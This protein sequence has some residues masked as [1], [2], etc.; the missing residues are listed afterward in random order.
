MA[1]MTT[2][3]MPDYGLNSNDIKY[4]KMDSYIQGRGPNRLKYLDLEGRWVLSG[5][6]IPFISSAFHHLERLNDARTAF[7]DIT[8][9]PLNAIGMIGWSKSSIDVRVEQKEAPK[10]PKP[11]IA[12]PVLVENEVPPSPRETM[13]HR[14]AG[15][16]QAHVKRKLSIP[17]RSRSVSPHRIET[18]Y[19]V[20]DKYQKYEKH[21][22]D[23]MTRY[24]TKWGDAGYA[25][26]SPSPIPLAGEADFESNP[27]HRTPELARRP[28]SRH[29]EHDTEYDPSYLNDRQHTD[30]LRVSTK[31]KTPS[32]PYRTL[33]YGMHH[34]RRQYEL[35]P[36]SMGSD[37]SSGSEQHSPADRNADQVLMMA[38]H[39]ARH[40]QHTIQPS[41]LRRSMRY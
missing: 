24:G 3:F 33:G 4:L 29:R 18:P 9:E 37:Y 30:E 22:K 32:L 13:P 31:E 20:Y 2:L 17:D 1:P 39:E 38:F 10:K 7:R 6:S 21:R 19:P 12:P 25:S 11:F 28:P 8:E 35:S 34:E 36:R 40:S 26:S 27:P 16:G 23:S 14:S 41:S 5:K 15:Y